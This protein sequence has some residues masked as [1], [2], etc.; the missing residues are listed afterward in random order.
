M[1]QQYRLPEEVAASF[2]G[3]FSKIGYR[4]M[5]QLH[6]LGEAALIVGGSGF[7]VRGG[8]NIIV[9]G[10]DIGCRRAQRH[11]LLEEDAVS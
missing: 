4:R 8:S 11:R 7:I 9:G 6:S 5:Q 10:I 3:G 1:S 2:I